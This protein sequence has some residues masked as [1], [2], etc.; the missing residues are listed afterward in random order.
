MAACNSLVL[1]HFTYGCKSWNCTSV[2]IHSLETAHS[3]FLRRIVEV[4]R[5]AHFESYS[6]C[7]HTD[8][9]ELIV[10]RRILQCCE[11]VWFKI[12]KGHIWLCAWGELTRQGQAQKHI[13]AC[14]LW[15]LRSPMI[16][17]LICTSVLR[18]RSL[19][20]RRSKYWLC[21]SVWCMWLSEGPRGLG[22]RRWLRQNWMFALHFSVVD[23]RGSRPRLF[24][25]MLLRK[26]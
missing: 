15:T 14:P 2:H 20:E 12:R 23:D 8:A 11:D 21:N 17:F 18:I 3:F 10:I 13:Q 7:L 9:L 25:P 19:G 6:R 1:T 4:D 5:S 24:L 26:N 16:G 22:L